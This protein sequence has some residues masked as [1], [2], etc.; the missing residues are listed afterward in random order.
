MAAGHDQ[1]DALSD[2]H[3]DTIDE[4]PPTEGELPEWSEDELPDNIPE[5]A[6]LDLAYS[7]EFTILSDPDAA[8]HSLEELDAQPVDVD[9]W[10]LV[11][12]PDEYLQRFK[13]TLATVQLINRVP[14]RPLHTTYHRGPSFNRWMLLAQANHQLWINP[15]HKAAFFTALEQHQTVQPGP[16]P[17]Q[18]SLGNVHVSATVFVH[19]LNASGCDT[20]RLKAYGQKTPLEARFIAREPAQIEHKW[21]EHN[22]WDIGQSFV[23]PHIW[24]F[25]GSNGR[26]HGLQH[27]PMLVPGSGNFGSVNV[28]GT[29]LGRHFSIKIYPRLV[30][31]IKSF[32]SRLQ[33]SVPKTLQ[34]IR[35]Q[36]AGALRM[37]HSLVTK[38]PTALGGFRIDRQGQKSTG[39]PSIGDSLQLP[40]SQLL[41]QDWGRTPCRSGSLCPDCIQGRPSCQCQLGS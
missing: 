8:S 31:V 29:H 20:I 3:P 24:L 9:R 37:I 30:H 38:N 7:A 41:A 1:I 40:R 39:C 21:A 36:V 14:A 4:D 12:S 11:I 22:E 19:C 5:P 2:E 18:A 6:R 26:Q 23:A 10:E 16:L 13:D 28:K 32:N 17:L 35:N 15:K 27:Y 34:G 33:G 25:A